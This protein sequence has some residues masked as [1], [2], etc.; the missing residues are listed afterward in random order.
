MPTRSRDQQS[1]L[2]ATN[3]ERK[4]SIGHESLKRLGLTSELKTE[5]DNTIRDTIMRIGFRRV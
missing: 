1:N 3:A 2:R 5:V 4:K